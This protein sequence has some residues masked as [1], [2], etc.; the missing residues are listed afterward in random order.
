MK[1][2]NRRIHI[3]IFL[4][5]LI[6][7]GVSL[8]GISFGSTTKSKLPKDIIDTLL[9]SKKPFVID[10]YAD[11]CPPCQAMIPIMEELEKKYKGR[12]EI[13]R[14]NVDLSQNRSLVM[15]YRVVSIPTFVFINRKGEVSNIIIGYREMEVMENEF[16]KL[17]QQGKSSK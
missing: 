15:N 7:F 3:A 4:F 12:V 8:V 10:F 17:L 5:L 1:I 14:V 13:V 2:E 16:R 11:W 6:S 9:K